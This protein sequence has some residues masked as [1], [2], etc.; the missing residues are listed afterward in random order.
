MPLNQLHDHG[1]SMRVAFV[2]ALLALVVGTVAGAFS[3]WTARQV[4]ED[5][6]RLDLDAGG[7]NGVVSERIAS[8]GHRV[9]SQ[10]RAL[11]SMR[12]ELYQL[13][14]RLD[15]FLSRPRATQG[16]AGV[17][18]GHTDESPISAPVAVA[19]NESSKDDAV[20]LMEVE[21]ELL[22][23]ERELLAGLRESHQRII[24]AAW[25]EY[26]DAKDRYVDEKVAQGHYVF[27]DTEEGRAP[28]GSDIVV[29]ATRWVNGVAVK[30]RIRGGEFE[31]LD[32]R[33]REW[34]KA[35]SD[36]RE[37][38]RDFLMNARR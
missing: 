13:A 8:L 35:Q 18:D 36:L 6:A 7:S 37:A 3:Y 2:V 28:T 33:A 20:D 11:E 26:R 5:L 31:E 15:W 25:E 19:Q 23:Y 32:A 14:L 9:D 22:P 30:V 24:D 1:P 34:W 4:R 38:E 21:Q 10:Q 16:S 27:A 12:D 17:D 29:S